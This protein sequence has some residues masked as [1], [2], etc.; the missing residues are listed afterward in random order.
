MGLL[1][2]LG[3]K[4]P[5]EGWYLPAPFE[6][7]WGK[8]SRCVPSP[9]GLDVQPK[10]GRVANPGRAQ[11]RCS[12]ATVRSWCVVSSAGNRQQQPQYRQGDVSGL[13]PEDA[14]HRGRSWW[15][16]RVQS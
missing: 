6:L 3:K 10:P 14:E 12:S 2:T 5:G 11:G 8:S 7:R 4:S 13:D 15:F 16:R 1:E 9:A